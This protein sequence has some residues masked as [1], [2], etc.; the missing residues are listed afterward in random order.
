MN[1]LVASLSNLNDIYSILHFNS[2]LRVTYVA[3]AWLVVWDHRHR[4][5]QRFD[6]KNVGDHETVCELAAGQLQMLALE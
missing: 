1:A 2:Y 5:P 3:P 4:P 6:F